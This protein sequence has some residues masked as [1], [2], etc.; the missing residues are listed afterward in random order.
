MTAS[1]AKTP[2]KKYTFAVRLPSG[3]KFCGDKIILSERRFEM[4]FSTADGAEAVLFY[5]ALFT[6]KHKPYK[7]RFDNEI[8][9]TGICIEKEK[10]IT[11][12]EIL[13]RTA[14]PII[15]REHDHSAN[16]DIFFSAEKERFNEVITQNV[17]FQAAEA[18]FDPSITDGF[19]FEWLAP[20]KT[21]VRHKQIL[22]EC[23]IGLFRLTGKP[24]LLTYLYEAGI[25]GK[26]S[27]GFGYFNILS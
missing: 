9:L 23:T 6:Q 11:T 13:C 12:P 14:M 24:E 27:F 3:T 26:K 17:R 20:K 5:N 25:S 15:A 2:L 22:I 1:M 7:S 21:V 10:I 4:F 16:K 19:T 18:G 8:A